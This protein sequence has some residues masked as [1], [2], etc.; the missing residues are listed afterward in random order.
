MSFSAFGYA[1]TVPQTCVF[2]GKNMKFYCLVAHCQ[3]LE[4]AKIYH[5]DINLDIVNDN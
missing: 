2:L 4:C 3:E 1:K 5:G